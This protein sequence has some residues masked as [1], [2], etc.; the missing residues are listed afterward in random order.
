L[1]DIDIQWLY[2][3]TSQVVYPPGQ[4]GSLFIT[5][6]VS[7]RNIVFKDPTAI[8]DS[9]C[10]PHLPTKRKCRATTSSLVNH[11]YVADVEEMTVIIIS[12]L[13]IL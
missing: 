1:K 4:E 2:W 8:D 10:N 3:H 5:T 9:E 11:Y 6:R 13:Y 7:E 12:F